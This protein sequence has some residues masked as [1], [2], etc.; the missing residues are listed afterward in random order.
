MLKGQHEPAYKRLFEVLHSPLLR[1]C[2]PIDNCNN[3]DSLIIQTHKELWNNEIISQPYKTD[4]IIYSVKI[5]KQFIIYTHANSL[6]CPQVY[7]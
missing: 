7:T 4:E 6:M 3:T 1:W 2:K 5:K